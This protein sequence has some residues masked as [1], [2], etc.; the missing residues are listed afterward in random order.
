M[1]S[2]GE[3]QGK[4]LISI[5]NGEKLGEVKDMYFDSELTKVTAVVA[6]SE[7]GLFTRKDLVISRPD[8]QVYGVDAWLIAG[9]DTVARPETIAD[10]D[11]FVTL[12]DLRGREI[13]TE[14]GT[15]IGTVGDVLLDAE[16]RVLGF[17]LQTVYVQG[18][19]AERKAI[20]LRAIAGV[21]SKDSPMLTD[22]A[23]AEAAAV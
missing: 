8:I 5:T 6:G 11:T 14:G 20:A 19:L 10:A 12:S 4:L 15:K 9:A 18:P 17:T 2:A 21:G 1:T 16:A 3:H 13:Q 7:G 23:D 22:L